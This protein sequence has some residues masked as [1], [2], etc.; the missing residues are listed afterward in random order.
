M[1]SPGYLNEKH[2]EIKN[3]TA[4]HN[5]FTKPG[6]ATCASA[7]CHDAIFW[8]NRKGLIRQHLKKE[9]CLDCHL[10]HAGVKGE[11]TKTTVHENIRKDANCLRCHQLGHFHASS[12][13]DDCKNCHI[14][15]NWKPARFDHA[16]VARGDSCLDCHHLPPTHFKSRARC[17]TCHSYTKWYSDKYDHSKIKISEGCL[18]C[19]PAR[20]NHLKTKKDCVECHSSSGWK[21]ANYDHDFPK[22]HGSKRSNN[23]CLTCHPETLDSY[24]CYLNCHEHDAGQ[25]EIK[26]LEMGVKDA[27]KCKKCHPFGRKVKKGLSDNIRN[28]MKLFKKWLRKNRGESGV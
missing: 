27:Y 23:T 15:H 4:C 26:H 12:G 7:K 10:E 19:H 8:T 16:P 1:Y 14:M 5:P 17:R 28:L 6:W 9:G 2:L 22:W 24:D 20:A 18:E 13:D 3:C 25:I 11:I 21:P